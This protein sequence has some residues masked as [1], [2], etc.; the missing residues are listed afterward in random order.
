MIHIKSSG[1]ARAWIS[2][3]QHFDWTGFMWS[4][5][6]ARAW[7]SRSQH[8]DWTEFMWLMKGHDHLT[9]PVNPIN[10]EINSV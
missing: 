6:D 3:S 4:S 9:P 2:R 1:D 8:F 10:R 5:G 7:I